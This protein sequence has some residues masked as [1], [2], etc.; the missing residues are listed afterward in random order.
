[1]RAQAYS[2]KFTLSWQLFCMVAVNVNNNKL[3]VPAMKLYLLS[4]LCVLFSVNV[5]AENHLYSTLSIGFAQNELENYELDQVS[6]K[7]GLAYELT[8]QWDIEASFQGL[9][10][11]NSGD[12]PQ[13]NLDVSELHGLAVS[14]L[15]RARGQ[16]GDLYY[17]IG[18]MMVDAQVQ[19]FSTLECT[20][21]PLSSGLCSVDDN[22][23]AGIIGLG[24]DLFVNRRT[25]LR[26]EVEHIE[27]QKDYSANAAYIGVR[28]NF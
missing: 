5:H 12:T 20:P 28:F 3:G 15:G 16:F 9:G 21:D 7:V 27:G 1:M 10:T 26:F 14:A 18:V 8:H 19:S 24:F 22:L 23:M 17:R 25:M 4:V 13:Q 2:R 6:Y 11:E